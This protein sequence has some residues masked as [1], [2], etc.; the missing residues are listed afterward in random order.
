MELETLFTDQKWN[1]LKNLSFE[2]YS[3]LQLASISNTSIANISQQLRLL[4]AAHLVQK[5]KIPNRDKGKPRTLFSLTNNYAYLI[6]TMDDFAEKKL[7]TL[8]EHHKTILKIWY[9]DDP[10]LHY[11]VEKLY[12]KIEPYLADIDGLVVTKNGETKLIIISEK[13][14][15]KFDDI[16]IKSEKAEQT[17][18]VEQYTRKEYQKYLKKAEISNLLILYDPNSEISQLSKDSH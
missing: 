8:S 5:E 16:H 12:W 6:S 15:K 9:L 17:V 10:E 18:K 7:L 2:R 13:L 4:E 1:I 14:S 11:H 3:P